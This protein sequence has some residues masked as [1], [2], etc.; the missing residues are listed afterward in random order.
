MFCVNAKNS[1]LPNIKRAANHAAGEPTKLGVLLCILEEAAELGF[2]SEGLFATDRLRWVVERRGLEHL[3]GRPLP[4]ATWRRSSELRARRWSG[5][6]PM[7]RGKVLS[8]RWAV[9]V[10]VVAVWGV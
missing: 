8:W 9:W 6:T 7:S 1:I 3:E 5:R 4:S 2:E 10:S